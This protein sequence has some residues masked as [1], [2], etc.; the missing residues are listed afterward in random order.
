MADVTD[1]S[2]PIEWEGETYRLDL[3][4]F[5]VRQAMVIEG[6]TGLRL[7]VLFDQIGD[8]GGDADPPDLLKVMVALYWLMRAQAGKKE[9]I[10]DVDFE[11]IPFVAA[12][13][14]GL[15]ASGLA[16]DAGAEDE[17]DPTPPSPP[18]G[19][20]SRGP[21]TRPAATRKRRTGEAA[22]PATA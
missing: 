4:R 2:V 14:A 13:S 3:G 20:T 15:A 11:L 10:A 21:S 9:A 7:A 18:P 6:Y 19:P 17:P 22:L 12:F 16:E 8:L 5:T 1:I